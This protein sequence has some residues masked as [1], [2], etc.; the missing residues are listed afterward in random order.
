M[1]VV[2]DGPLVAPPVGETIKDG[3]RPRLTPAGQSHPLFRFSTEEAENADIWN[4]LPALYWYARGYRR[5]LAAEVL[6]VHPERP[7]EPQ[8]GG[9]AREE[10]HPLILQQF[11]GSG[12][13]MFIGFDDTWRWRLR[14]DEVRFNQFWLQAVQTLARGRVGRTEVRTDRKTYRRDDPMRVTVR[15]PDD[16]P[17]PEGPVKVTIDRQPPKVGGGPPAEAESQTIQLA[18]REGTRATFEALVTR[19]PEGDY[20]FTLNTPLPVGSPPRADARV[21][22][23]PGELDRIQL[24]EQDLQRA[25][26]ES[27]GAYYPLDRADRLPEELPSGP[28][29]ALD[30]PVAPLSL[31]N[32]PALFALVLGLLTAE[33]LMRKKWRLL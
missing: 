4:R 20:T 2:V 22:P 21:L 31:W 14:E 19:T 23:P 3:F 5:K 8:P 18:P 30:Q 27:R 9:A 1:P 26:R 16:A 7:A 25:A 13:V 28:R 17:P 15:F 10:N 29:V 6:A 24:N 11:V 32:H 12:R 33:W